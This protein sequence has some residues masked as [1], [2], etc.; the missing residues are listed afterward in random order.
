MKGKVFLITNLTIHREKPANDA[1][2]ANK[3]KSGS[4]VIIE[5]KYTCRSNNDLQ[6]HY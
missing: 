1:I 4:H 2:D 5:E 3:H 6:G